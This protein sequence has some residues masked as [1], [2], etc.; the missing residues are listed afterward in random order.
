[1]ELNEESGLP[2]GLCLFNPDWH[3][4]VIGILASRIKEKFHRPVIAFAPADNGEIKGS[5][6]SVSG[7]HIRDA[8]DA[9]AKK[10]PE[11]LNKFG[12]HAMAAGLSIKRE[13]YE[14]FAKLFDA[15][16]RNHLSDDDLCSVIYSDG[17]LGQEH[18]DLNTA[19]L[20]RFAGPWGQGF[21]EP[22]FDGVFDVINRRVVG[23][24][25]LKLF[26]RVPD[27]E[28]LVD[29]IAFNYVDNDWSDDVN[30]VKLAYQLDINEFQ[31]NR[32][33]QI[34]VRQIMPVN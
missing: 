8:L 34:V 9:I 6:R 22:V 10:H 3:Q 29:A 27:S 12:G 33:V 14:T 18:F 30:S 1:M 2:I 32:T 23:E 21:P 16:V 20:L 7:L 13:H 25:H 24:K 5:A 4:G 19:E 28:K 31:G 11:I 17:E 15:E 26:L